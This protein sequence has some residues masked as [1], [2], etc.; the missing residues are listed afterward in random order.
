MEWKWI[1]FWS[2]MVAGVAFDIVL[3]GLVISA[4]KK[5]E[6]PKRK[7]KSESP[8]RKPTLKSD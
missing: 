6:S 2:S 1:I 8:K 7:K 5:S 3:V 4:S